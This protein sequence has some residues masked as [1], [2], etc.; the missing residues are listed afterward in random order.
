MLPLV[1][2][3]MLGSAAIS[4]ISSILGQNS[5][6][7]ANLA[8]VNAQ[9]E[10]NMRLA[11]YQNTQN[12]ALWREQSAYNT[13][14]MQMQR[15]K[16]AGL[17]PNLIY[18]QGN[19]GNASAAPSVQVPKLEAYT[20]YKSPLSSLGISLGQM[21]ELFQTLQGIQNMQYQGDVLKANAD[22]INAD[23]QG[24]L[25]DNIRKNVE[26]PYWDSNAQFRNMQLEATRDL[27][28]TRDQY[29][30][31]QNRLAKQL[32]SYNREANPLKLNNISLQGANYSSQLATQLTHR[33]LM[34]AQIKLA[35]QQLDIRTGDANAGLL[36]LSTSGGLIN[37]LLR[38]AGGLITTT[39][40]R[41]LK[42]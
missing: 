1:L 24:K 34:D 33:I 38:S 4:G 39:L 31:S 30:Q 27:T 7:N 13:P 10:G 41:I 25:L 11:E 18:G 15:F 40:N 3:G 23:T 6:N 8:A 9:N 12:Q 28:Y 32:Y 19:S 16:E 36:G 37:G 21:P 26:K 29:T 35:K 2:G 20:G 14:A 42:H 17:N 5:A 22:K